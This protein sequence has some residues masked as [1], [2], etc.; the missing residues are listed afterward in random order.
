MVAVVNSESMIH[1]FQTCISC[2]QREEGSE[3]TRLPDSKR[4]ITTARE[5]YHSRTAG[6]NGRPTGLKGQAVRYQF[7]I[8]L[9][10]WRGQNCRSPDRNCDQKDQYPNDSPGH[11]VSSFGNRQGWIGSGLGVLFDRSVTNCLEYK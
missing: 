9:L 11:L 8:V 1:D 2:R 6:N 4:S 3:L 10:M 7:G 5:Q